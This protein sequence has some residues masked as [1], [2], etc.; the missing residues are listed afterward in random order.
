MASRSW[1]ELIPVSWIVMSS[2]DKLDI[3]I[4]WI[5]ESL[6]LQ[7]CTGDRGL[8][9]VSYLQVVLIMVFYDVSVYDSWLKLWPTKSTLSYLCIHVPNLGLAKKGAEVSLP[10][11]QAAVDEPCLYHWVMVGPLTRVEL[12]VRGG[13]WAVHFVPLCPGHPL[14]PLHLLRF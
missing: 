12:R 8:P 2:V 13:R 4:Y 7:E 10:L 3:F 11:G 14:S 9:S 5:W 6:R 1:E